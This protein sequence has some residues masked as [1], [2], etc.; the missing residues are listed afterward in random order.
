MSNLSVFDELAPN[1][2]NSYRDNSHKALTQQ[3]KSMMSQSNIIVIPS[4]IYKHL[5]KYN[6]IMSAKLEGCL[7]Y[8]DIASLIYINQYFNYD[9]TTAD[10]LMNSL[11]SEAKTNVEFLIKIQRA[12]KATE[13]YLTQGFEVIKDG[14]PY[15][16]VTNN[17]DII[18]VIGGGVCGALKDKELKKHYLKELCSVSFNVMGDSNTSAQP[19]FKEFVDIL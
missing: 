13:S 7:S 12:N 19:F 16:I 3:T 2:L 10:K 11:S 14:R 17:S 6:G 8:E 4:Y 1:S 15:E 18:I 9:A 5:N